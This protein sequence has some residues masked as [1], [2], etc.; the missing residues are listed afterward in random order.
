[1][2][3]PFNWVDIAILLVLGW[4]VQRGR[5]HG[6]SEELMLVIKWLA[7]IIIGAFSY[8]VLGDFLVENTVFSHLASYT[9]AYLLVALVITGAFLGMKKLMHGKLIGSDVFGG[10]EYYL[11][12]AAGMLRY[13]CILVFAFAFIN[14]PLYSQA[15][16]KQRQAYEN[17]WYGSDF[18]PGFQTLQS[19][20]FE[21][22]FVG[23]YIHSGLG[24]LLIKSTPFENKGI[25]RQ[26]YQDLPQ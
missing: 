7:I 21:K 18:F 4:G 17:E 15:D 23:P 3:L 26:Q 13:S 1:M 5:K 20:V 16:I 12:M 6:M 25:K 9:M 8:S 14:A 2:N 24:F 22:S 11:G 10:A 19:Q